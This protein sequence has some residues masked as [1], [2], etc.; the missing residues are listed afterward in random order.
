MFKDV[1][2]QLIEWVFNALLVLIATYA[3]RVLSKL[4]SSV[5]SLNIKMA[6]IVEQVGSHEK[7][8]AKIEDRSDA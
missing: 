3:V 7:R 2:P 8:I 1:D 4:E 6:V 5:E